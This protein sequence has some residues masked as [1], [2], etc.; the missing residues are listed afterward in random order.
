[1]VLVQLMLRLLLR[2]PL[3]SSRRCSLLLHCGVQIVSDDV[4]LIGAPT[5]HVA[6]TIVG[7]VP[8][9][10]TAPSCA[11]MLAT[12]ILCSLNLGNTLTHLPR[13]M[14]GCASLLLPF[15]VPLARQRSPAAS[16]EDVS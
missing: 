7:V 10:I 16:Q 12:T 9:R 11:I 15:I 1:M 2:A 13:C 4:C 6:I 8:I 14:C 3:V 5:T